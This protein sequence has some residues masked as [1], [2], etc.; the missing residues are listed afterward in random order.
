M[1]SHY[2]PFDVDDMPL[3]GIYILFEKGELAHG[4]NRIVRIGTHTGN[5]QLRSR[6]KQ[7]YIKENKDRSIFRK[8]I[9]RALLNRNH[10]SFMKYWNLDLTTRKAKEKY[11]HL[12]DFDYQQKIEQQVTEYIQSNLFF[13][14]FPVDDKEKRL[15]LESKIISTVSNCSVC[16]P[17]SGWLG[18][19]SPKS[20]IRE[21][22]LWL[23][24]ELYKTS[25]TKAE[26]FQFRKYIKS[27]NQ[28]SD[29]FTLAKRRVDMR[30]EYLRKPSK[31]PSCKEKR[32]AA[33]LYGLPAFSPEL[34][35]DI[36]AGRIVLGGC[37]VTDDDPAWQC[38]VC[39]A[40]I[41]RKGDKV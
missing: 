33:I 10:D 29:N 36:E 31:C 11:S 32:I 8:N 5:N 28:A 14:V 41:F 15:E 21:S 2:Y 39:G 24:N 37:C 20:K 6:L 13:V 34:E 19:Y 17:S 25:L 27:D 40:Q 22:G 35:S 16:K 1:P 3:N 7:H 9:G 26:L 38:N 4:A 12:V 23:E 30:Y 18:L